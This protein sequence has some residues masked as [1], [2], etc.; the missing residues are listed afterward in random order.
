MHFLNPK[1]QFASFESYSLVNVKINRRQ[2]DPGTTKFLAELESYIKEEMETRRGYQVSNID[3]DLILRYEL[4]SNTRNVNNNRQ[5]IYDLRPV[6]NTA[7][8]YESVI[9]LELLH[10]KKLVWQG[11]YDLT[12]SRKASRNEKE[13][14]KAIVSIFTTYPYQAGKAAPNPT[15]TSQKKNK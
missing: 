14:K 4:V 6:I 7:T 8:V 13:I 1:A 5:S 3:P 12:Q 15:L 11:S 10:K 9:L 2:L